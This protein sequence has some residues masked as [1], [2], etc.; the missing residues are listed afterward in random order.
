MLPTQDKIAVLIISL[1]TRPL[2]A[3]AE[4]EVYLAR[5][6]R[7]SSRH[8]HGDGLAPRE[9]RQAGTDDIQMICVKKPHLG[10]P[11]GLQSVLK[12]VASP[13]VHNF[14]PVAWV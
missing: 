4:G 12:V 5:L 9:S 8:M 14:T 1:L 13:V 6:H 10:G 3:G 7:W 11:E 2:A